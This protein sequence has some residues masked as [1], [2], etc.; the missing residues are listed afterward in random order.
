MKRNF[1]GLLTVLLLVMI[2]CQKEKSFEISNRPSEGSLQSETTGDCLPKTV[3]GLYVAATP[4]VPAVN[5][6]TVSVEVTKTGNYTI[7]SDTINGYFFRGTGVFTTTGTNTV[8][9]RSNGTPFSAGINNFI[10]NYGNT[11]CDVAITVLPVGSTP[12]AFTLESTAGNCGGIVVN[13]SYATATALNFTNT[14]KVN[15]NVTAIGTYS[16]STGATPVNGMTFAAAG[17]FTTTGVQSVTLFGTGTPA[18]N[19]N[20]TVPITAGTS[21]CS[22]VIPVGN[23]ADGTL[24]GAPGSCTTASINGTYT[25]GVILTTANSVDIQVNV[26]TLGVYSITTNTVAG[27][28]FAASGSFTTTGPQ[29]LKLNGSG[30]P[31]A[32]GAQTF[33]V[34][35]GTSACTFIVPVAAPAGAA[36][37]TPNCAGATVNGTYKAGTALTAANTIAIPVTVTTAGS[38]NISTTLTNGMIFTG[39]G[40]LAVGPGTITLV[41]TGSVPSAAA[42]PSTNIPIPGATSCN[43]TVTVA[44][45]ATIDWSFKIGTTTY[46]GQSSLPDIIY[47]NTTSPPFAYLDYLGDNVAG[48]EISFTLL[49]L[50]GGITAS[51]QYASTSNFSINASAFYFIDA[52]NTIDLTAQPADPGPPPTGIIGNMVFTV[53]SHVVATKTIIG[54]FSGTAFDAKSNTTKTIT[55]GAFT[56]V[57]K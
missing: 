8:T 19:G 56:A 3:N 21:T 54:T 32:S 30:T 9:L 2:G 51:E 4:L 48:D 26:T 49:D 43:V 24:G 16:I 1:V 27:I 57:Y 34:T 45:A 7:Y 22:F 14:V 44:A 12:A 35:F 20:T 53:T 28:K 31:T 37:Y 25:S 15:V 23:P 40:T 55:N 52:A 42:S 5:T 17:I 41:G 29:S 13:G 33:T 46:Q 50:T 10:I 38:Y 39:S 11:V 36:V 6:I 47:D 18:A